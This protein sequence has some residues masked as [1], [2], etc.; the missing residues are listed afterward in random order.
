MNLNVFKSEHLREG[1]N[2]NKTDKTFKTCIFRDFDLL[3]ND[4]KVASVLSICRE[5]MKEIYITE[6]CCAHTHKYL[7][8]NHN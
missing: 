5:E 4:N 2:S 7:Q 1:F 8:E 6:L 3:V